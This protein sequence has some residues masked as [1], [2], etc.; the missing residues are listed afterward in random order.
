MR[1]IDE[2]EDDGLMDGLMGQ[3]GLAIHRQQV[4]ALQRA[5]HLEEGE[6]LKHAPQP[7]A[8]RWPCEDA[9]LGAA[10]EVHGQAGEVE[11]DVRLVD[12]CLVLWVRASIAR[13]LGEQL[14]SRSGGERDDGL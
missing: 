14:P 4:D 7:C 1:A 9:E 5:P 3:G 2:G 13:P 11:L 10:S 12:A 8:V 6:A